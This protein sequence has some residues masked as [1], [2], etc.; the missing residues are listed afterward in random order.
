MS[1]PVEDA[2]N[3]SR[4][5]TGDDDCLHRIHPLYD[6]LRVACRAVYHPQQNLSVDEH[7]VVNKARIALKKYIKNKPTKWEIKL[8]A[9]S[10]CGL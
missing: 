2:F 9:L 1:D 5:G 4:K 3:N 8:F 6:S 10:D 7:M